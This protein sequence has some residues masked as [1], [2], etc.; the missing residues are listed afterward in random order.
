MVGAHAPMRVALFDSPLNPGRSFDS[1]VRQRWWM[2][3][4]TSWSRWT[5][6]KSIWSPATASGVKWRTNAEGMEYWEVDGQPAVSGEVGISGSLGG[7][8]AAKIYNLPQ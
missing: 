6:G 2:R 7:A 3:T 4:R 1:D 5:S 8:N